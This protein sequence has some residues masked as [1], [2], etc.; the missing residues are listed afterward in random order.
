MYLRGITCI[1]QSRQRG[2]D[3]VS[4]SCTPDD[5]TTVAYHLMVEHVTGDV[6]TVALQ[7]I[8]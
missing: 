8:H 1:E 7:C 2:Y 4:R 6:N 5:V 3:V